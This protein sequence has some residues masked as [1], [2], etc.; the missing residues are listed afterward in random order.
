MKKLITTLCCLPMALMFAAH[1]NQHQQWSTDH[2]TEL[3][4]YVIFEDGTERPYQKR[5]LGQQSRRYLRGYS[6]RRGV[7]FFS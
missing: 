5:V 2:L 7:V 1:G 6:F 3:Q 4:K